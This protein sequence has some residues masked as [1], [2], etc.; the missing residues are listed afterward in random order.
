LG[1]R[2]LLIAR[3]PAAEPLRPDLAD[4]LGPDRYVQLEQILFARAAAWAA[5]VA[6][7]QVHVAF[8]P[9]GSEGSLRPLVGPGAR[10]FEQVGEGTSQRVA[11]A[12]ERVFAAGNGP[13]LVVWP[14][15]SRWRPEHAAGA[16]GDLRDGCDVSVGPVYDGGFYLLALARLAPAVFELPDDGWRRPEAMGRLLAA[17]HAAGLDAGLLRAERAL[18]R[19]AD[20]RAALAD[21][22]LDAELANVLRAGAHESS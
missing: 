9:A 13:V 15:L 5:G 7:D 6:A 8:E 4:L 10:L 20:V 22:L 16:L 21:P 1:A 19:P 11:G 17:A 18:R 14:E 12:A 3:D 2:V